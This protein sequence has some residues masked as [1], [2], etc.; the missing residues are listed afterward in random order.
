MVEFHFIFNK[1]GNLLFTTRICDYLYVRT[2]TTS[3]THTHTHTYNHRPYM[4]GNDSLAPI[5]L[6]CLNIAL[7]F[8][9]LTTFDFRYF[10]NHSDSKVLSDEIW[11]FF[12][13]LIELVVVE[14][15]ASFRGLPTDR[16]PEERELR[17]LSYMERTLFFNGTTKFFDFWSIRFGLAD[18]ILIF[19]IVLVF[20]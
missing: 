11:F 8:L 2:R 13:L 17:W 14:R 1:S 5:A 9:S 16:L 15:E 12:L 3:S 4:A 6:K 10:S 7:A 20:F 19:L 18:D